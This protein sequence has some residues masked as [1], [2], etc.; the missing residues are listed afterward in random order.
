[1]ESL[2]IVVLNSRTHSQKV[3]FN[4]VPKY[5]LNSFLLGVASGSCTMTCAGNSAEICG[6]ANKN[7]IYS[8]GYKGCYA[9]LISDRDLPNGF[10]V[11]SV[12]NNSNQINIR[13]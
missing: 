4:L 5:Y 10:Q 9:D 6:G 12:L 3:T 1:M 13:Y 11:H 8:V 7:S 2:F